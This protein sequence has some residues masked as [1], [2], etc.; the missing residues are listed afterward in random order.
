MLYSPSEAATKVATANMGFRQ[1]LV[2]LDKTTSFFNGQY[3]SKNVTITI[4]CALALYNA[5]ELLLL[6]FTTFRK[7][8]GLYFWSMLIATAGIVPYTI[9][10]M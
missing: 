9:G 4:C 2:H 6:I 5:I 10:F 1:S 3:D 8:H 7:Y